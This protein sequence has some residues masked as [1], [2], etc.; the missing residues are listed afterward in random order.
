MPKAIAS[1][2]KYIFPVGE[3]TIKAELIFIERLKRNA[4]TERP[5]L[6]VMQGNPRPPG[7]PYILRNTEGCVLAAYNSKGQRLKPGSPAFKAVVWLS[8][9]Y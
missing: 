4:G 9:H 1:R 7:K 3:P 8:R 6:E 5:V 2:S